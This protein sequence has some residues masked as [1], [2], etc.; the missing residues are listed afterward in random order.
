MPCVDSFFQWA[1]VSP[2]KVDAGIVRAFLLHLVN[3]RQLSPSSHDVCASALKFFLQVTMHRPEVVKIR[4]PG[5]NGAPPQP[6][7]RETGDLRMR[8]PESS[9]IR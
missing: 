4:L 9:D 5:T 7:E 2:N 6:D 1:Q 8:S 3:E